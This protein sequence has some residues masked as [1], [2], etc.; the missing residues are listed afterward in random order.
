MKQSSW[1]ERTAAVFFS[2]TTVLFFLFFAYI[3]FAESVDVYRA[4]ENHSYSV[5]TDLELELVS[6]PS[7]PAGIRK[8]Y[9][10]ILDPE[11]SQESYLCF[12]ISHHNIQVYFGDEL[13]YSLTGAESNRI[14]RNV[15][16][17]WCSIYVGAEYAGETVT[18]ILTP[19][20]EA[21]VSKDATFLFGSHYSIV[22]DLLQ[23][24]LP[25]LILCALCALLGLAVVAVFLYFRYI[26]KTETGGMVYMGLFSLFLGLWKMTDLPS[27]PM[28]LPTQSMALSYLSLISLFLSGP[29]LMLY[30]N[31]LFIRQQRRQIWLLVCVGCT[32][33]LAILGMQVFGIGELRQNLVYSHLLLIVSMAS[34][35]ATA[36]YNRIVHKKFGLIRSWKLLFFLF[37]GIVLDLMVYYRNND[38]ATISFT[39][40][41]LMIYTMIVFLGMIQNA[42]RRINTDS[43]TGLLS[44]SR[45]NELA[46]SNALSEPYGILVLDLNG[47]KK[48]NDTLG[49]DMGD[50]MIFR[51]SSILRNVLPPTSNICRWGGDEFAALLTPATRPLMDKYLDA[52]QTAV[53]T[54][55]AECPQLPIHYAA[56]A[57]LSAEHPGCSHT[58]LFHLADEE[59]YRNKQQ[60]Y[61][62]KHDAR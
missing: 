18:V 52:L 17:N 56:G 53:Q 1:Q 51:F 9:T 4:G 6:D 54:Y 29:C 16:S 14:G 32:V 24:E 13:R 45:W 26:V 57:A 3:G 8:V 28:L 49:H 30:L 21:A 38:N 37:A 48:V 55:N 62:Q 59:M 25:Q 15:G 27:M 47:L 35:P 58:E 5:Y 46:D 12:N 23:R 11:T 60:W 43:H 22:I 31:T 42:T 34:L 19:L 20:F 33:C 40:L 50:Q 61:A 44:R 36:L 10:G 39:V 41:G 7:A 2:L